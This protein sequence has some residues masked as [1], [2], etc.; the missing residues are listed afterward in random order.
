MTHKFTRITSVL[1]ALCFATPVLAD[2]RDCTI[3]DTL[4]LETFGITEMAEDHH[5]IETEIIINAAPEKVWAVLISPKNDWSS[6]YRG[7]SGDV[8]NGGQVNIAWRM[9][10]GN[11]TDFPLV[12]AHYIDGQQFGWSEE[13]P[14]AK[15]IF[16]N[17][18]YRVE[19]ISECQ[20]RFVQTDAFKGTSVEN[21]DAK[22][23]AFAEQILPSYVNFNR[24][25]KAAAE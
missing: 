14:N 13:F 6:S 4:A 2:G 8:R 12:L 10:N 19:A 11:L 1:T 3:D 18:I 16:D 7:I 21:P 22:T 20:T 9:K 17:H 25:L 5:I 24:E 23:K 15:G